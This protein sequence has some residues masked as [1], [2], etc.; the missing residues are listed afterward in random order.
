MSSIV[1]GIDSK[2]KVADHA[3]N[4]EALVEVDLEDGHILNK[5]NFKPKSSNPG[6]ETIQ[7][8]DRDFPNT[9]AIVTGLMQGPPNSKRKLVQV[10]PGKSVEDVVQIY[11][12]GRLYSEKNTSSKD[13]GVEEIGVPLKTG[14]GKGVRAQKGR[15]GHLPEEQEAYGKGSGTKYG[16]AAEAS[17]RMAAYQGTQQ[18]N[19]SSRNAQN[20]ANNQNITQNTID[21]LVDKYS[22]AKTDE[23][24]EIVA[25]AVGQYLKEASDKK[26]TGKDAEKYVAKRLEENGYS[27]NSKSNSQ[28]SSEKTNSKGTAKK[29]A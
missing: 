22:N 1:I 19:S 21:T 17:P 25:Q 12:Q 16:R 4:I 14:A 27:K 9:E 11:K 2:G 3:N 26:L 28:K 10:G 15:G 7:A 5:T 8:T 13:T 6:Q 23:Q 20:T 18:N 24:K 29:A